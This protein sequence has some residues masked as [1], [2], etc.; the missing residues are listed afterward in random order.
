MFDFTK[1]EYELIKEKAMLDEELSLIL[2]MKIKG[3]SITKMAL[4]LS[5]SERT[6]SRRI[7][8]LKKKIMKVKNGKQED[9]DCLEDILSDA[10]RD[11]KEVKY[12]NYKKYKNKIKGM[13]YNYK[14]DEDMAYE[15]VENMTPLGEY[16]DMETIKN[17]TGSDSYDM[18]VV[19]NSLAND[20]SNVINP[21]EVNTYINMANAWLNDEDAPKH[22]VWWYF[23]R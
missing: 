16:W 8:K 1:E 7:K 17:A 6:L 19:M 12:D 11:L 20:Y 13:A 23:V 3:Y 4:E 22:K 14:I 10:L 2:E 18:Y 21:E 5:I 15:I 9:M